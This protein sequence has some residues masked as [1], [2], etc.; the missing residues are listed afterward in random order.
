MNSYPLSGFDAYGGLNGLI[1]FL[2]IS[3]VAY[4]DIQLFSSSLALFKLHLHRP[5]LLFLHTT[6]IARTPT[7]FLFLALALAIT[8]PMASAAPHR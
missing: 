4:F 3:S 7:I 6:M 1:F 8:G 2:I 5:I